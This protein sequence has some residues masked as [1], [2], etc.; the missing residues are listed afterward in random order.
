MGQCRWKLTCDKTYAD[1]SVKRICLRVS[2]DRVALKSL[3]RR[4]LDKQWA[5]VIGLSNFRTE[6]YP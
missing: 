2:D 3:Y 5:G 4:Y 6:K 1:G